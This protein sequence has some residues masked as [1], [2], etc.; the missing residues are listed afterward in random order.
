M[1]PSPSNPR[2]RTPISDQSFQDK[3]PKPIEDKPVAN[4][5]NGSSLVSEPVSSSV[6]LDIVPLSRF[7]VQYLGCNTCDYRTHRI[8]NGIGAYQKPLLDLYATVMRRSVVTRSVLVFNQM[9]EFSEH[10]IVVAEKDRYQQSKRES[11]PSS[12]A[13]DQR[14]GSSISKTECS[15]LLPPAPPTLSSSNTVVTKVITPLSNVL[16]WA[17]V[18]L[19]HRYAF[20]K[21]NAKSVA[22]R[23]QIGV[24]FVPLSCSEAVLDK[25]AFVTLATKQR[26][27]L[28]KCSR[29]RTIQS[30]R[31]DDENLFGIYHLWKLVPG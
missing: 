2:A 24:A 31:N 28:S 20:H 16:L 5:K 4:G 15:S 7:R 19:Q 10:G 13:K 29:K 11:T 22:K 12:V 18:K 25:N 30:Y 6:Q 21:I 1:S 3:H 17:A 14:P 23:R 27:L 26:F 8:E 9:A